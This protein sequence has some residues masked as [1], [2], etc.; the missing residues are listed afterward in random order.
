MRD[1]NDTRRINQQKG[2]SIIEIATSPDDGSPHIT[3]HLPYVTDASP[4]SA[5]ARG[6]GK[7]RSEA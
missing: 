5:I 6:E 1:K 2:L 7:S 3:Y 4:H